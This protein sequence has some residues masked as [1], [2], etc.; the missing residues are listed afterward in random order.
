MKKILLIFSTSVLFFIS[1]LIIFDQKII[2]FY[3]SKNLSKA[4]GQKVII[5]SINIK[6]EE[7]LIIFN[8]FKILNKNDFS[9]KNLFEADKILININLKS[10]FSELILIDTIKIS[11]PNL[12]IE[13]KEKYNKEKKSITDNLNIVEKIKEDKKQ[14]IYPKKRK[15]KNFIISNTNITNFNV[16]IKY[17]YNLKKYDIK[18]SDIVLSNIGN[19]NPKS[20][21]KSQHYKDA[22]KLIYLDI[23]LRISDQE[24]KAYIKKHYKL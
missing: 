12:F 6:Y 5:E 15:D 9:S 17:P 22:F 24:L 10:I 16:Y 7:G 2:S 18:L 20:K 14:K 23:Y 21:Y 4:I 1:L 13:I 11:N 3:I 8:K 19:T